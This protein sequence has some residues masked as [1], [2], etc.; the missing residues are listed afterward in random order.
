[1]YALRPHVLIA[2]GDS[3]YRDRLAFAVVAGGMAVEQVGDGF[4]ALAQFLVRPADLLVVNTGL[5]GIDHLLAGAFQTGDDGIGR[6][7]LLL[8]CSEDLPLDAVA[9]RYSQG[10]SVTTLIRPTTPWDAM[11]A[12]R[13]LVKRP[14]VPVSPALS[15][16]RLSAGRLV[17][18][19]VR[20]EARFGGTPVPTNAT[21]YQLL[22][23][24]ASYPSKIFSADAI[25]SRLGRLSGDARP[26]VEFCVSGLQSRFSRAGC[27]D[28]I[29]EWVGAG[30]RLGECA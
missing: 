21:E 20:W 11:V 16:L 28:L 30:Y 1:M 12:I 2:H 19:G 24:L 13:S 6:P 9:L 4:S 29:Q 7:A 8:L 5:P 10:R 22:S 27:A 14:A 26:Q 25:S 17:L 3:E 23:L 15:A 18:D